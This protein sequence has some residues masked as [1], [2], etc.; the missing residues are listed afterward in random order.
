MGNETGATN[1]YFDRHEGFID[2]LP[3]KKGTQLE[4][5]TDREYPFDSRLFWLRLSPNVVVL[6]NGGIKSSEKMQHSPDLFPSKYR[7]AVKAA[8]AVNEQIKVGGDFDIIGNKII[9]KYGNLLEITI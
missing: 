2:A 5:T 9:H 6:F 3:S 4:K 7:A 8:Q 1:F